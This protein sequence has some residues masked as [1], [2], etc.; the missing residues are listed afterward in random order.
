[1]TPDTAKYPS[2]RLLGNVL[3]ILVVVATAIP[4]AL[5]DWAQPIRDSIKKHAPELVHYV[6]NHHET[7]VPKVPKL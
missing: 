2:W 7:H 5:A 3:I 6:L 1:M 4:I